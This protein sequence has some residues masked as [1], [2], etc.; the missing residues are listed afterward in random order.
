[1]CNTV[2]EKHPHL[3]QYVLEYVSERGHRFP[4]DIYGEILKKNP[5]LLPRFPDK[6]I[7]YFLN[8]KDYNGNS[9]LTTQ[10]VG[11][12][13]ERFNMSEN[14]VISMFGGDPHGIYEHFPS[15]YHSLLICKKAF[16]VNK[17]LDLPWDKL[18]TFKMI[19]AKGRNCPFGQLNQ[20][21]PSIAQKVS[22]LTLALL[23]SSDVSKDDEIHRLENP[24]DT[25][26]SL[27]DKL[28][29][30]TNALEKSI[31]GQCTICNSDVISLAQL[32]TNGHHMC[33][34]C[35]YTYHSKT[36]NSTCPFCRGHLTPSFYFQHLLF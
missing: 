19:V 31:S 12:L 28:E 2:I 36:R 11:P 15:K 8:T 33:I 24:I 14:R 6:R 26:I 9:P 21:D 16:E 32:C 27:M 18:S 13:A 22:T 25:L 30:P 17:R 20:L 3:I 35:T 29:K 7:D 4:Y 10:L 23:C 1:M 34:Q 5:M